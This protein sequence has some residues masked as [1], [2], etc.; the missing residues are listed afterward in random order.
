MERPATAQT[1]VVSG[2]GAS[3]I[4]TLEGPE[5][6]TDPAQF[7]KEFREAPQGEHHVN[8]VQTVPHARKG[9]GWI[10]DPE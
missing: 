4:G 5:V 3:L 10:A 1:P 7:P 9:P 2:V 8:R 6:I